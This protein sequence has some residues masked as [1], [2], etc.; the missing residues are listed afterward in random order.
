MLA[1]FSGA[2]INSLAGFAAVGHL[3]PVNHR[4]DTAYGSLRQA[5]RH[6]PVDLVLICGP[7]K[8][9]PRVLAEAAAAGA[10]AAVIYGDGSGYRSTIAD[11]AAETGI[12]LLGP[13]T[14]GFLAPHADL[15][16]TFLPGAE[17]IRPGG[18]AVVAT[19][20]GISHS[21]ACALTDAG[22]GISLAVGLDNSVDITVSDVLG[23]LV[24]DPATRA[25]ALHLE[26]SA[27]LDERVLAGVRGLSATR[28]VVVSAAARTVRGALTDAGAVVVNHERELVEAVGALA[29]T[30]AKPAGDPRAGVVAARADMPVLAGLLRERGVR[31]AEFA[32]PYRNPADFRRALR[33]VAADPGVDVIAACVPAGTDVADLARATDALRTADVPV[34]LGLRGTA[35]AVRRL[36]RGTSHAGITVVSDPLGVMSAMAAARAVTE[37]DAVAV[38]R[39]RQALLDAGIV[40]VGDLPGVATA[41]GALT[42]DARVATRQPSATRP[43]PG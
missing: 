38:L 19:R 23:H 15:M 8:E 34:V 29:T 18:V 24:D 20:G 6:G 9:C 16:A 25:V 4:D 21:L 41:V 43:V 17:R 1:E 13:N 27:G 39:C 30:R 3:A 36:R 31:I 22:F 2:L 14:S 11:T 7:A 32:A 5:A 28:P 42:A 37:A 33:V 10:G 12:R 26:P 40:V 35:E